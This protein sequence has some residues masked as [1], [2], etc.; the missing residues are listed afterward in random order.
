[1]RL[2]RLEINGFK[3]F[4]D[5]TVFKFQADG[6]TAVVGPNGCGKSN[7][8][9]AVRWALGEQSAK[10]LR[11]QTME[12]VIFNGS[13]RRKPMGMAEV[14]LLF[15]NDGGLNGPWRD[16]SEISV[17]RRLYLSGESDYLI[18][19]VTCRLKDVKELLADAGGSS[20]GYS[21][22]EQGR[23]SLLINSKPE[24]KRAL[25][26]EA[27]GVLK[28]RMRRQEAE[29]KLERTKQNLL[30]VSDIIREVKRQFD[31]LKRSAAKARR[32]R[33]LRDE[34]DSLVLRVRYEEFREIGDQLARFEK[35][36]E[37]KR[38][39]MAEKEAALAVLEAREET[40]R[41]EL[42]SGEDKITMSF[43][44]VRSSETEIARLESDI[45]VREGSIR[46]LEERI[47]NLRQDE[48]NLQRLG[49]TEQN[50]R[51]QLEL[52]L[53]SIEDEYGKY[54]EE[55]KTASLKHAESELELEQVREA[56]EGARKGLFSLGTERSRLTSEI[57][58][59][60]KVLENIDRRREEILSR[61][62]SLDQRIQAA[63]KARTE[64]EDKFAAAA[65]R[66]DELAA[67][68]RTLKDGLEAD[69]SDLALVE[70]RLASLSEKMA[71]CRGLQRTLSALEE[72]MEGFSDSVRGVL[73]E[74]AGSGTSGILGVVADHIQVPQRYEKAVMAVL[75]ER[76]QHVIVDQP[77]NGL[78][79]VDYLKERS[80]GRSGFIPKA[81]RT[82]GRDNGG[83]NEVR[84]DGVL[85][86]LTELVGFSGDLNGIGDFLLGHALVVEDLDKALNLWKR[87]GITAT[88]VTLE[89]DVVEPTGVITGGSMEGGGTEILSRKRRL[90]EVRESSAA[91]EVD[92]GSIRGRREILRKGIGE[93]EVKLEE[94]EGL[95]RDA[96]RACINKEGSL[97]HLDREVR[98]LESTREDIEAEVGMIDEEAGRISRLGQECQAE[99]VRVEKEESLTKDRLE[100]L[101]RSLKELEGLLQDRR[102]GVEEARI[103]VNTITL[104]KESSTRALEG[105][106]TRSKEFEERMDRMRE[107]IEE[108]RMRILVHQEEM[109]EGRTAVEQ[110]ATGLEA[111]KENLVRLREEQ[112]KAR[113]EAEG[114]AIEVRELRQITGMM[115]DEISRVDIRIHELRTEKQSLLNRVQEEHSLDLESL[116]PDHFD[117]GEFHR[118]EAMEMIGSLRQKVASLGEVNP[119]AVEE[120][121]ELNQ[122]YEFLNAQK[123]DL[124]DSIESLLKAIRK[125]NRKSKERFLQ[126]F[127]EVNENFSRLFP[128]LFEGGSG[129]MALID[130]S[131]PLNTGV[132]INVKPP[133][134]KLKS[135][136]LLSGGEK[137]LVSLT[138]ILSMFLV[139][140]SPFC[141][142]DEV[143]APLDDENL[144]HFARIVKEL[145]KGYQF[146]VITHN[147]MTMEAADVLYGITMREPGV[148]Q[149][150]SVR[151]K[152]VA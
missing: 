58:S 61:S 11:G 25:I 18:N 54:D 141:I 19:G 56:I 29:R 133:G 123:E 126:T 93:G 41:L 70:N 6:L 148:S 83:L 57:I 64:R 87:N 104:K 33:K 74:Y 9:D 85:G 125:I 8:V 112:E 27:A 13:D 50:E 127:R 16:Y 26:E 36:L 116:A 106:R 52:E 20:R 145:S 98:Q 78:S 94:V 147:K 84:E 3:S 48:E 144:I 21:I 66:R 53:Q 46:S 149:V 51:V 88:M 35:D 71:E 86:P 12:D 59:G 89:G 67:E 107:E 4:P 72:E 138:M 73:K 117:S 10:L 114:V 129:E 63:R 47:Q 105:A 131:D 95:L 69:R 82:N 151:L 120:F 119:A 96:E 91:L 28:Y 109:E 60:R 152:D 30:R 15:E 110:S 38:V 146:L 136:Q 75:G 31:S 55:L 115:R 40:L 49:E 101:E 113:S 90:K 34:L 65:A 42:S 43:E 62:A 103:R 68:V 92:L 81:P 118:A 76:I 122:R 17:S 124:E 134:K 97:A 5:R 128:T 99:M 23:I 1:M 143:D 44:E 142:L 140:P 111:R 37:E 80:R 139:K 39:L 132:E 22:V 108:S 150:V 79:A 102:R 100:S 135:M 2:K 121:E 7:I 137:A 130:E 45:S 24:E 14:T 32:Y 77:E